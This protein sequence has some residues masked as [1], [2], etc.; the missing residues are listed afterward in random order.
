MDVRLDGKCALITGGSRGIGLA[1]AKKFADSGADVAILSRSREKL[2]Q[3]KADIAKTAKV[4]VAAIECNVAERASLE[5]GYAQALDAL[6]KIDILVNN[7]GSS[8][9]GNFLELTDERWQSDFDL[10]VFG[11]IRFSRLAIPGM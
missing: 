3:A 9:R 1:I 4:R 7:A 6:G 5:R 11:A 8:Q 2:D 10:K